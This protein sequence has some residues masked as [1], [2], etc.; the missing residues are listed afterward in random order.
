MRRLSNRQSLSA[1]RSTTQADSES[2]THPATRYVLGDLK[3]EGDVHD[4]EGLRD[5]I[6]KAWKDREYDNSLELLDSVMQAGIRAD[7]QE[8]GYFKVV[9]HDPVS[10]PLGLTDGKQRMLITTSVE[11]GRQFRLGTIIITSAV[12]DR[13]LSFCVKTLRE[14]FHIHDGDV[15]NMAEIRAGWRD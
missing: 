10:Q 4:G 15:F 13:S 5:R 9:A 3:I 2:G 1:Q 8:R 6:L 12:A 14:Q 11:E 7:F